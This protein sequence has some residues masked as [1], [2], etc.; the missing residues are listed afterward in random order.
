MD[1]RRIA[2]IVIV[3]VVV[4]IALFVAAVG[5]G[6]FSGGYTTRAKVSEGINMA[7]GA[8]AAVA[9]Y[10]EEHGKYP[11]DNAAASLN[12]PE[13]ITS[14]YVSS[15]E[16]IPGGRVVVRMGGQSND[17]DLHG[18]TLELR[19]LAVNGQNIKWTCTG[20]GVE[21]KDLPS[22]CSSAGQVPNIGELTQFATRYAAAWSG[23]DPVAFA[24][25]YVE[26]GSLTINDGQP[27]VGR[28][29]VEQTA[30]SFMANFPDMV[31]ELVELRT[32]AGRVAFHWHWTGTNTGPGGTGNAVDLFGYEEWILDD[33]GFVLE[34]QGRMDDAEYQRQLSA[35]VE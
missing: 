28:D 35:G 23:G 13:S 8:K 22:V 29:A 21:R 3:L 34:S 4:T 30:R 16:V 26:D 17:E 10:F 24:Q 5:S 7:G 20:F 18:I 6:Y 31:V 32:E 27:S 33:N 25:F 2:K 1:R 11:V 19:A 9:E 14:V 15:V 12:D